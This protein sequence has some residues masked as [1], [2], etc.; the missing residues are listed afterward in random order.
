MKRRFSSILASLIIV[1]L[2]AGLADA[3]TWQPKQL[4]QVD[5]CELADGSI[6]SIASNAQVGPGLGLM[7]LDEYS[8]RIFFASDD[9]P[10]VKS[11][12]QY[13]IYY[14][15]F[16]T[17]TNTC[18]MAHSVDLICSPALNTSQHDED[19]VISHDGNHMF[20]LQI[21]TGA[22]DHEIWVRD[23]DLN[24]FWVNP[25][26][27]PDLINTTADEHMGCYRDGKLYFNRGRNEELR[28]Y[29]CDWDPATDTAANLEMLNF[30]TCPS[31]DPPQE[32]VDTTLYHDT[33]A[34]DMNADFQW[35]Y[36]GIAWNAENDG[37]IYGN[38][39]GWYDAL[40]SNVTY[41]PAD[42]PVMIV[43]LYRGTSSNFIFGFTDTPPSQTNYHY[44]NVDLGIYIHSTGSIRP[45]WD[46]N[47]YSYWNSTIP[48]GFYDV[49]IQ[50][51]SGSGLVSYDIS[52]VSG[53]DAP[54]SDFTTSIWS[55]SETRTI[56]G[57]YHIHINDYNEYS[58]IY[59]VWSTTGTPAEPEPYSLPITGPFLTAG[60]YGLYGHSS[61]LGGSQ[62]I[63]IYFSEASICG[64]GSLLWD[65]PLLLDSNV[66]GSHNEMN[67][68]V[69]QD[70]RYLFF[71][72]YSSSFGTYKAMFC[73]S[74]VT[75][76]SI[77]G[78]V[79]DMFLSQPASG[80]T[81][82]LYE[83]QGGEHVFIT[84]AVTGSAGEYAFAD[85]PAG[86]YVVEAVKPVG[87]SVTPESH[88]VTLDGADV[89]NV[90]FEL[91]TLAA[92]NASRDM[93]YWKHQVSVVL[94]GK[95]HLHEDEEDI[96]TN[97]PMM[98]FDSF[99][100]NATNP[101]EIVGVS[102]SLVDGIASPVILEDMLATLSNGRGTTDLDRV[103]MRYLTLLLNV[104]SAKVGQTVVISDDGA[105]VCQAIVFIDNLIAS[106][107]DDDLAT[108]MYIAE[109]IN[110]GLMVTS[111]VIPLDT[112]TIYFEIRQPSANVV[113][114]QNWP[115]PF[116]PSTTIQFS[117]DQRGYH[118]LI[119]YD[120]RGA[121]VKVL[122]RGTISAG[123]HTV[124]WDGTNDR[125]R[126]VASGVYF[127]RLRTANS[128]ETKK[129]TLL[130]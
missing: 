117:M 26:K 89:A 69:S 42:T 119:V 103:E 123:L 6:V 110:A 47:N 74:V 114:K 11:P 93:G 102:Y 45:S 31:G 34:D 124:N 46:V 15:D 1:I 53:W 99:F 22:Y 130:R 77:S 27:L 37:Y 97:F 35:S 65:D 128:T 18:G 109:S 17:R 73:E 108:A 63:D 87:Y 98:I 43:R 106:G 116:N 36:S 85:L 49:R 71:T 59:D 122:S 111:G 86:T 30:G 62:G 64:D 113:L 54:L 58:F 41:D 92:T 55:G 101:V 50:L 14:V 44:S 104:A 23:K 20:Y 115:N 29:S 70:D 39:G 16:D 4:L 56:G 80:I 60:G 79:T 33:M 78:T 12:G 82:A 2:M 88:T 25:R 5:Q 40:V 9:I 61:M 127:Y 7:K 100:D 112:P 94:K 19:P 125:G 120:A 67:P 3:Q 24:G 21:G 83:D 68:T 107:T 13:D 51:E 105:Q 121:R 118:D 32:P 72:S 66:N 48:V 129:M 38:T 8:Y 75:T 52:Q 96:T 81:V 84:D 95:G 57:P 10:T 28:M 76:A 91:N 126:P 90:D